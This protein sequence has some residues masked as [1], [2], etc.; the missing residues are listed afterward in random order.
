MVCI[1]LP[2]INRALP[3][4]QAWT[5]YLTTNE[6]AKALLCLVFVRNLFGRIAA[7]WFVT[8]AVDEATGRN[9]WNY[10]QDW[11]E[12]ALFTI[13]ACTTWVYWYHTKKE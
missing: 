1:L 5:W 4:A 6:L 3:D 12:V 10:A 7:L 2:E 8:Q 13:L 11:Q 9:I